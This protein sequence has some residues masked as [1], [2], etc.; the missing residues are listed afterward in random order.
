MA[1]PSRE[2]QTP[3]SRAKR[4]RH[5]AED[6][7]DRDIQ[8][9]L[10]VERTKYLFQKCN[11]RLEE[12][13]AQIKD[14]FDE[15]APLI[16]TVKD[17]T[18]KLTA[19]LTESDKVYDRCSGL[20]DRVKDLSE[21]HDEFF[22]EKRDLITNKLT[23]VFPR[24][25]NHI[26]TL[27]R[28]LDGEVKHLR[29]ENKSLI[30]DNATLRATLDAKTPSAVDDVITSIMKREED[31]TNKLNTVTD[32]LNAYRVEVSDMKAQWEVNLDTAKAEVKTKRE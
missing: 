4:P 30:G 13:Y 27:I 20:I 3:W 17:R 6:A 5:S 26:Q 1:A 7:F 23:A 18:T 15:S 14:Q 32:E 10:E 31:A 9:E 28:H 2:Q 24:L 25:E 29:T 12:A 11:E 22:K 19:E 16:K 8:P 21:S